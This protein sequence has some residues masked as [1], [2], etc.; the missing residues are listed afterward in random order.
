MIVFFYSI[1]QIITKGLKGLAKVLYIIS[2][3]TLGFVISR[4]FNGE[5]F[6]LKTLVMLIIIFIF[7]LAIAIFLR[8]KKI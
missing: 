3:S 1:F 2:L 7:S 4:L 6:P 5:T 8:K